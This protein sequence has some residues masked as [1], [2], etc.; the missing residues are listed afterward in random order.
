MQR[1]WQNGGMVKSSQF[2]A[3]VFSISLFSLSAPFAFADDSAGAGMD[4]ASASALQDTM[5]D[6]NSP[7]NREGI[8]EKDPRAQAAD[9]QLKSVAG[10]NPAT[11]EAMYGLSGEVFDQIAKDSG[12]NVEQMNAIM[13]AAQAN[14][15]EFYQKYF[16]AESK[17][18]VQELSR[19]IS[20]EPGQAGSSAPS[21]PAP[22]NQ[23]MPSQ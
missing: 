18:K 21:A 19:K 1:F 22:S 11:A 17:G 4:S 7:T 15:A 10:G 23:E 6:L 3:I 8:I 16:N 14:P 13:K 5:K 20:S 2:I 12:G 9:Q